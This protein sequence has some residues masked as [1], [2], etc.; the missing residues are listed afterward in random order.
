LFSNNR[1]VV[2]DRP[3]GKYLYG[4]SPEVVQV[5]PLR[6]YESDHPD[7]QDDEDVVVRDYRIVLH[8]ADVLRVQRGSCVRD[9]TA[10]RYLF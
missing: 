2:D 6:F 1:Y 8:R 9:L 3:A 7:F 10:Y 4:P 5:L